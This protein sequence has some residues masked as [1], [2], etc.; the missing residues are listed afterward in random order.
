MRKTSPALIIVLSILSIHYLNAQE[1]FSE[2]NIYELEENI[3]LSYSQ[4]PPN[5]KNWIGIY[6]EGEVPGSVTSTK[7]S[8]VN[9]DNSG[10]I[11][12]ESLPSGIYEA[13]FLLNDI[14]DILAST[15]FTVSL[16]NIEITKNG[17][18]VN[19]K[20]PIS[21]KSLLQRSISLN[22]PWQD[23]LGT[24]GKNEYMEIP[25][26]N[27]IFYRLERKSQL[28][29]NYQ[30][31][32]FSQKVDVFQDET[33][34]INLIAEDAEKDQLIYT[35]VIPPSNGEI[36]GLLPD[37]SYK[38]KEGYF[39]KDTFSFKVNDGVLDSNIVSVDITILESFQ[40]ISLVNG[41]NSSTVTNEYEVW[42]K[43][44]IEFTGVPE[45]KRDVFNFIGIRVADDPNNSV[46]R[47]YKT[48]DG[49]VSG[50]KLFSQYFEPGIYE[51]LLVVDG[52]LLAS[53]KFKVNNPP[54]TSEKKPS[55]TVMVYANGDNNLTTNL[56]RDLLEMEYYGSDENFNIIVQADFDST[57]SSTLNSFNIPPNSQDKTSRYRIIKNEDPSSGKFS[58]PAV[59]IMPEQDMDDPKVLKEFLN[60]AI[61]DYPAD[62]YG[63]I[64]WDHGG[65]F[66]GFGGDHQNSQRTGWSGLFTADIKE[67]LSETLQNY[68]I[69]KLD[70]ISFDTCLMGG[71]EVLV[72]FYELCDIYIANPEL[73]YGDGWDFK[74]ALGYL[75]DFPSI[76]SIEFAKKEIEFWD[77]HHSTQEAD[78]AYKVHTA[79]DMSQFENFNSKFISF[80]NELSK[81]SLTKYDVVPKIRRNAIQYYN[82][83]S[84]IRA[85]TNDET[86]FIDIGGFSKNLF[87]TVDG[88]LKV[89]SYELFEAINSLVISKSVG[90]FRGD[91]TGLSIYYP[92]NGGAHIFYQESKTYKLQNVLDP[93]HVRVNFLQTQF[94]GDKWFQHLN[95]TKSAWEGDTTPPVVESG[96][97]GGKSGRIPDWEPVDNELLLSTYDEPAIL[98]FEVTNGEDAYAVYVSL[99]T[100][101]LTDNQNLYIY[102]SEIG[103]AK[104]HGD[105]QYKVEWDS[106]APIISLADSDEYAPI[107]LGGWAMEPGSDLFVSF[108][109][110]QPPGSDEYFPLILVTSF[111]E[112]GIGVIDT[113]LDDTVETGQLLDNSLGASLSSTKS[114]IKLEKGGKLWPVYFSEELIDDTYYASYISF[115]DIVIEIPE[116]GREGLE[117]SFL[118]VEAGDYDIEI[119]TV[120]YFNNASEVL[121][122]FIK[123]PGE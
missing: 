12:F 5:N 86:D 21:A 10:K 99:V 64:F 76:S 49:N 119:Q 94:G 41:V 111:D 18:K 85:G 36:I 57:E 108:A 113:V 88:D 74:N 54:V 59:E 71:V 62:R 120:D 56:L 82:T 114:S 39:G 110:Y 11:V 101:A 52:F 31:F 87:E 27:S 2:K 35:I 38:P 67:V 8:Y 70:F 96:Q 78:K 102:L 63:L 4:V 69:S 105:G 15:K 29:F 65:Q 33:V 112:F 43:I 44:K 121:T 23:V 1:I 48:T 68:G 37:F 93:V 19:I 26:Q 98:D 45:E 66:F 90:E 116:N 83:G 28:G 75:K 17:I 47:I 58:T 106:T 30:P 42:D 79:Y 24:E 73:D 117:V 104:L 97:G 109:D 22:G 122:Y 53:S 118:P 34:N 40:I 13:H 92:N 80:S 95:N 46:I 9:E 32:A 60:W 50:E 16:P 61:S 14:Y 84:R 55:W 51:A 7:W 77:N 3:V 115:E 107:Y 20:W 6:K 91:A 89:A 100:N 72:D 25:D 123:V 81:F 103:S